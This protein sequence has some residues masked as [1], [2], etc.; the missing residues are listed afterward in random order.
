MREA[1]VQY[2]AL[3]LVEAAED[4][5]RAAWSA[6]QNTTT[7]TQSDAAQEALSD[8]LSAWNNTLDAVLELGA[9]VIVADD[10]REICKQWNVARKRAVPAHV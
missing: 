1:S 6:F 8:A 10:V 4:R 2:S 9:R 3:V 7:P 5:V